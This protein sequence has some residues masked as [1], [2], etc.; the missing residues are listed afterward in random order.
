MPKVEKVEGGLYPLRV[1]RRKMIT[2]SKRTTV[3]PSLRVRCG[4]GCK[5][6]VEIYHDENFTDASSDTLEINGVMGSVAQWRAILC[7]LLGIPESRPTKRG[8]G[9]NV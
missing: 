8:A 7:P 4:C 6:F 1:T 3:G 2:R 9:K 5:R